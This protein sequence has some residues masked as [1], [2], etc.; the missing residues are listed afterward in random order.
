MNDCG[1]ITHQ[2]PHWLHMDLLDRERNLKLLERLVRAVEMRNADDHALAHQAWLQAERMRLRE[3][4][5]HMEQEDRRRG[6]PGVYPYTLLG[7]E[8]ERIE[9]IE[10]KHGEL[11]RRLDRAL[12]VPAQEEVMA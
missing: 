9:R 10:Q 1:C 4:L 11:M 3:K 7:V 2:G 5:Y 6:E 12:L 8:A